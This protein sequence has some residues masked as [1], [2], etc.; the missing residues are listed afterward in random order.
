MTACNLSDSLRQT[1]VTRLACVNSA[2]SLL[3]VMNSP[4]AAVTVEDVLA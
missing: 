2:L 3:S 1:V 4:S